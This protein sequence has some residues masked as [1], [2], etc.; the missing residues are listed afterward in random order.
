LFLAFGGYRLLPQLAGLFIQILPLLLFF[1]LFRSLFK[2][3]RIGSYLRRESVDHNRFVELLIHVVVSVIKADGKVDEREIRVL[4]NF[5]RV[6]LFYEGVRIDWVRD[7]I[8][9]SLENTPPLEE[10]CVEINN[11][12]NSDAKLVLLQLVYQVVFSDD[13]FSQAERDIVEKIVRLLGISAYDHDRVR[14]FFRASDTSESHYAV[15]GIKPGAGKDEIK[16]AYR[17]ATK[18]NHPDKVHHLGEE[19]RKIAEEK[20]QKINA[21]YNYLM[22]NAA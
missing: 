15:L 11:Q 16:R 5:F 18:Q 8:Q 12:F 7:L 2:N 3:S 9:K 6:A 4:E 19:F 20:M 10:V 14:A 21:S 22:K 1:F 13:Q 17:E